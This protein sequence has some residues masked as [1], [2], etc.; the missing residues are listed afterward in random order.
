MTRKKIGFFGGCFNP[1]SNVHIDL[2]KKVIKENN[3]DEV[4]FVPVGD[5]YEKKGLATR[6]T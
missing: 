3:L 1:P 4:I 2:A 6:K 5:F